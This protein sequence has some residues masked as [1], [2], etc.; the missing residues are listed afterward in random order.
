MP[1][2]AVFNEAPMTFI[3]NNAPAEDITIAND[4]FFP[5]LS[6]ADFA[7]YGHARG[8]ASSSRSAQAI[9]SAMLDTNNALNDF[10]A[11]SLSAG[12]T[13]LSHVPAALYGDKTALVMQYERAVY[14]WAAADMADQL[15]SYDTTNS[16]HDRADATEAS[17]DSL[18]RQAHAARMAIQGQQATRVDLL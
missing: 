1:V 6:V 11:L 16:G 14:L 15:R 4:G 8:T 9:T 3:A 5:A 12:H 7:A 13:Q 18:R 10:K 2:S 17:A